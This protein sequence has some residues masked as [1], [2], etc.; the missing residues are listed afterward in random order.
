MNV[1]QQKRLNRNRKWRKMYEEGATL[2]KIVDEEGGGIGLTT[3][4]RGIKA[5]GGTIRPYG[6]SSRRKRRPR[7]LLAWLDS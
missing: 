4:S 7:G 6:G 1:D 5:V 3:I 2:Q